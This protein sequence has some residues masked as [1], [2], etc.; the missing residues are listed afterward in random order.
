MSITML[1]ELLNPKAVNVTTAKSKGS[2]IRVI[3]AKDP[4]INGSFNEPVRKGRKPE[5]S[6][7]HPAVLECR[8]LCMD[9]QLLHRVAIEVGVNYSI[10]ARWYDKGWMDPPKSKRK[11]HKIV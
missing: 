1:E 3:K 5:V 7:N 2:H 11:E 8:K 9:G 4:S 10:L 6:K